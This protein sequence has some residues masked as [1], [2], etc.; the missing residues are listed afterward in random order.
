[1]KVNHEVEVRIKIVDILP[2]FRENESNEV[3]F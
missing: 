1:M 3:S 2:V